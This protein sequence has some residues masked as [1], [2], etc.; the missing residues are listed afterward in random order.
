MNA[1]YK[2]NDKTKKNFELD[3]LKKAQELAMN[4]S[5]AGAKSELGATYGLVYLT[6]AD[7]DKCTNANCLLQYKEGREVANNIQK[8]NDRLTAENKVHGV[9]GD[10]AQKKEDQDDPKNNTAENNDNASEEKKEPT[11]ETENN[12]NKNQIENDTK[13]DAK[14][15]T[16]EKKA[17]TVRKINSTPIN[18]STK[19]KADEILQKGKE[20]GRSDQNLKNLVTRLKKLG[21]AENKQE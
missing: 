21:L 4:I 20:T 11:G 7:A 15:T 10:S 14:Q 13:E 16:T 18:V 8:I 1:D 17:K 6:K 12:L 2:L 19:L 3:E 9:V 5:R